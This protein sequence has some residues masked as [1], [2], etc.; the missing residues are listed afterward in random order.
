MTDNAQMSDAPEVPAVDLAGGGRLPLIGFGTWKLKGYQAEAAVTAA[1][2]AG[3]RHIDTAVMYGNEAEIGTALGSSGLGREEVFLT[4]KIRPSDA[5]REETVLRRSLR[6]LRTDYADLWLI[7]WPP[8][9]RQL[10]RQLWNELRRLRDENLVRD[11][12]VSNYD[13]AQ[14]DDLIEA[15]GEAPAVNQV[16][17][18]PGRYDAGLLEG[19]RKRGVALEGYSPLKGTTL[20]H[21][22]LTD[23]AR[24]HGVSAAQVVLRWHLDHAIPVIPKSQSPERIVANLDLLGFTLS[25]VE[26]A[27]ID[28]LSVR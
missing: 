24:E 17:W 8:N 7:H 18:N 5:G 21:P 16:P 13:L 15:T 1:L 10:S 22:V 3:C 28:G 4:T 25:A 14:I 9:Q 27:A 23:I 26:L 20:D 19:H 2:S 6:A 11:I 12:G